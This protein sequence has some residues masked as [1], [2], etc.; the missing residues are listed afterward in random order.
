MASVGLK[1]GLALWNLLGDKYSH[2]QLANNFAK[3]DLHRHVPGQGAQIPTAGIEDGAIT[4]AKLAP[5]ANAIADDSVTANK[6]DDATVLA[7]LGLNGQ[8]VSRRGRSDVATEE[9]R[10]SASY[11]LMPTPDVVSNLVLPAGGLI[12]VAFHGLVKNSVAAAGRAAIFLD[13][14][15]TKMDQGFATPTDTETPLPGSANAYKA[16]FTT[17]HGLET[18]TSVDV[19]NFGA[20][21]TTGQVIGGIRSVVGG[22]AGTDGGV[23]ALFA[24]AGTYDVSIQYKST[25]GSVSAKNR[26]LWAWTIGF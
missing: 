11:V 25:S 23:T 10:T 19:T 8:G 16:L 18:M 17:G 4:A 9:T 14:V 24:D 3:L 22:V 13:S 1:M 6:F 12:I 21:V 20:P 5:G 7:P 2:T 26:H 15:Q